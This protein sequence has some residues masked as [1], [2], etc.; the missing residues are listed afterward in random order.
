MISS[1]PRSP[2][3]RRNTEDA[4]RQFAAEQKVPYPLLVGLGQDAMIAA[5]GASVII[6]VS[7]LV[8]PDGTVLVKVQGIHPKD[9]FES[10]IQALF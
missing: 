10:Q 5:Y 2:S 6:P 3:A 8:K 1:A 4:I 7:W 9:W